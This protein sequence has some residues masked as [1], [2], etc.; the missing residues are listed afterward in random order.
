ME[1]TTQNLDGLIRLTPVDYIASQIR[2]AR[3]ESGLSH[4]RIAERMGGGANRQHLIK[5]EQAKHR[6]QGET[7]ARYAEATGRQVEWFLNPDLPA[8]AGSFRKAAA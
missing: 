2:R 8:T 7:L 3:K 1:T 4:D 6:P 5:L